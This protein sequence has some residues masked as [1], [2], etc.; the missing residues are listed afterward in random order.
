MT[1]PLP[2]VEVWLGCSV[3][4]TVKFTVFDIHRGALGLEMPKAVDFSSSSLKAG[5]ALGLCR[6]VPSGTV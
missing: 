2:Q 3:G 1:T 5:S 4:P 6:L